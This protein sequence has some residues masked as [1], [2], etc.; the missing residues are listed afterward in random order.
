MHRIVLSALPHTWLLDLDGTVLEHN[1][2]MK[3]TG[4]RVLE[5]SMKFLESIPA[6]DMIIF[7]TSRAPSLAEATEVLLKNHAIRFD[8]IIYGVPFGER[9]LVNDRKPSGLPTSVA[10]NV[11]RDS[12]IEYAIVI[13]PEK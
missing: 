4:E 10:I 3:S 2:Y 13:D 1:G 11:Q 12:G 7:L 6:H 9:I 5:A 8:R